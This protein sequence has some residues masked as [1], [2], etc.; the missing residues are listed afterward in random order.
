MSR[1]Q[2]A[3]H[4]HLPHILRQ[5]QQPHRIGNHRAGFAH[6]LCN[7]LL[8]QPKPV[9]QLPVT[10]SFLNG[11]EVFTLQVFDQ[12]KFHRLGVGQLTDNHR[13]R[14]KPRHPRRS[15][16]AL[17]CHQLIGTIRKRTYHQRLQH[18]VFFD[19]ICQFGQ[20]CRIEL[21][22]GLVP[23]RLDFSDRQCRNLRLVSTVIY[24]QGFQSF[25][26]STLCFCQSCSP[27]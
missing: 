2:P 18:P 9:H 19:R 13:H 6:P 3:V 8:R 16:S 11:I 21:L 4:H 25:S 15:P 5:I 27:F 23:I 20:R 10:G 7:L 22:S 14:R 26:K 12:R 24:K 1:G 17:P